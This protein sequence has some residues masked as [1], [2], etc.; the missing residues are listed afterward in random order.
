MLLAVLDALGES[1][2]WRLFE[3]LLVSIRLVH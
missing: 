1:C 2:P 3:Q